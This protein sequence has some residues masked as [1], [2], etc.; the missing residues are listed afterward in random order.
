VNPPVVILAAGASERLGQCKALVDLGGASALARLIRSASDAGAFE[1]AVVTGAHDPEIA[2]ELARIAV[3]PSVRRLFNPQWKRGRTG[4]LTLAASHF[5]DRA[6]LVAPID[7]PLVQPGTF[8]RLFE[9]WE[10]AGDPPRGWLAACL[11]AGGRFGHPIVLGRALAAVL[12]ERDPGSA[13]AL[14][15]AHADP[16]WAVRVSDPAILDDLDTPED[17]KKLR[18]RLRYP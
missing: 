11:D 6:L 5:P 15:R 4:S 2:D 13:L 7:V 3:A 8:R 16:L 1:I 12:P 18:A 9:D 14:V 10:R 17:L